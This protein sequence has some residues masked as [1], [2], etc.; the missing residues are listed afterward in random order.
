[1]FHHK[2]L[3]FKLYSNNIT[4]VIHNTITL[5]VPLLVCKIAGIICSALRCSEAATTQR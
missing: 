5:K 1:M 2:E 3:N 4:R